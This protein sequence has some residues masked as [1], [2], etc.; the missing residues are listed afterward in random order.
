[1]KKLFFGA[2][3]LALVIAC[4]IS[5]VIAAGGRM[6]V[7]V[8]VP[9]PPPIVFVAP[10]AMVVIPETYVYIVPDVDVDIFFYGGW[11]WR[12]WG[13]RWYRSQ[14]YDSGWGHYQGTP[15]FYGH[16][17]SGWRNDYRQGR[18][19]GHQWDRRRVPHQEVQKN[20]QGWERDRHWEKQ[21]HWGVK[22]LKKP[23]PQQ[24]YRDDQRRQEKSRD[25]DRRDRDRRDRR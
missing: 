16:V 18:W 3:L 20:W 8:S 2:V 12:P 11:W 23:Q 19:K 10:P 6:D 13:G 25:R 17:P 14:R 21:N 7:G 4:P 1:M 24:K 22:G 15:S 5:P 9:L